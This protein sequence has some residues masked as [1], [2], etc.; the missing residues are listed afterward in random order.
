MADDKKISELPPRNNPALTDEIPSVAGGIN[1]RMPVSSIVDLSSIGNIGPAGPAGPE[2]PIGA[3]GATGP[4]GPQGV[5]GPVAMEL[6]GTVADVAALPPTGNEL[7]DAYIVQSFDP[8]HLFVWD[9]DSW[10]DMG[11]FQGP[12]GEIGPVGPAGPQGPQGLPGEGGGGSGSFIHEPGTTP[13]AYVRSA[14]DRHRD[15]IHLF[16]FIPPSQHNAMLNAQ[17]GYIPTY[18]AA[19]DLR[20][21][22]EQFD[23]NVLP[24]GT[25]LGGPMI[26]L[27][28][29]TVGIGSTISVEKPIYLKGQSAN[30]AGNFSDGTVLHFPVGVT[31]FVIQSIGSTGYPE[32]EGPAPKFTGGGSLFENFALHTQERHPYGI[33]SPNFNHGF[34]VH[35]GGTFRDMR[36]R[37]FGGD[38]YHF[39]GA[40]D[41]GHP[42]TRGNVN[43]FEISGGR[44]TNCR[45]GM[46]VDGADANAGVITR[47]DFSGNREW[48]VQDLSFLGNSYL[49]CHVASNG[50]CARRGNDQGKFTCIDPVRGR[51]EPPSL[52]N[53]EVW[54][55]GRAPGDS[56]GSDAA[57]FKWIP[58]DPHLTWGGG[59]LLDVGIIAHSYAEG[60]ECAYFGKGGVTWH[61]GFEPGDYAKMGTH[62]LTTAAAS[63]RQSYAKPD[64]QGLL[65]KGAVFG[66]D[67]T[68]DQGD[69]IWSLEHDSLGASPI[70][71]EIDLYNGGIRRRE[72]TDD[73]RF[74]LETTANTT[75][76][77]G[78]PEPVPY[79]TY[80]DRLFLGAPGIMR[81]PTGGKWAPGTVVALNAILENDVFKNYKCVTAG[82]TATGPVGTGTGTGWVDGKYLDGS[83]TWEYLANSNVVSPWETKA[84]YPV[85][86][87]RINGY[88][89]PTGT[90]DGQVDGNVV[91]DHLGVTSATN[92]AIRPW[93]PNE[94]AR[95]GQLRTNKGQTYKCISVSGNAKTSGTAYIVVGGK[96]APATGGWAGPTGT[97]TSIVDGTVIWKNVPTPSAWTSTTDTLPYTLRSNVGNYYICVPG[98]SAAS[99]GPTGTANSIPGIH[100]GTVNWGF[101]VSNHSDSAEDPILRYDPWETGRL[102]ELTQKVTNGGNTYVCMRSGLSTVAPTGTGGGDIVDG[103]PG[104]LN[105]VLVWQYVPPQ[106]AWQPNTVYGV[107]DRV[108]NGGN[109]YSCYRGRTAG[110]PYLSGPVIG[111]QIQDGT[112]TWAYFGNNPAGIPNWALNTAYNVGD[113]VAVNATGTFPEVFNC[114]VA[115]TSAGGPTGGATGGPAGDGKQIKDNNVAWEYIPPWTPETVFRTGYA[116]TNDSGKVYVAIAG[117]TAAGPEG[118][119]DIVDGTAVWQHEVAGGGTIA[120]TP[121]TTYSDGVLR[122]NGGNT[123]RCLKDGT[124]A[125]S[126][127]PT[128]FGYIQDGTVEWKFEPR[129]DTGRQVTSRTAQ[130]AD[131]NWAVGDFVINSAPT[132]IGAPLGWRCIKAGEPALP[133]G[134][135]GVPAAVPAVPAQWQILQDS[136]S[137]QTIT[138][139]ASFTLT[140]AT[141]PHHTLVTATLTLTRTC[142]LSTVGDSAGLTYRITRTGGGPGLLTINFPTALTSLSQNEWCVVVSDGTNWYLESRGRLQP[143]QRQE[144]IATNAAFTITPFST[145]QRVLHT[146]VLTADRAVTL[147]TVNAFNGLTYRITRSGGGAFNLNVGTGPLKA[148]AT[149]TWAEFTFDGA[150]YYLAAYGAL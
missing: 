56:P 89:G 3:T 12:Q 9:G 98:I 69:Q 23:V 21:A 2:G 60:G 102:Y 112:V 31:G 27:P 37:N 62:S 88:T 61:S 50:I 18:D 105:S 74:R 94:V 41:T 111:Q 13:P 43:R 55:P 20:N 48:G 129:V 40:G 54:W 26:L 144:T 138:A 81:Q 38:G 51:T 57:Y 126:G 101:I 8:D 86:T 136:T 139:D 78:R 95:V 116:C 6:Q 125:A 143:D 121:L 120:W 5:P 142:T 127:G 25:F 77:F 58:D 130:P 30:S 11:P 44:V 97:G 19:Q 135:G 42:S 71:E 122:T 29:G 150:A 64:S 134:P 32:V 45:N 113:K 1:Y 145:A 137:Q 17:I 33:T 66:V 103:D 82:T 73:T 141:S 53:P 16:D 83:V 14:Q 100:D 80:I 131:H 65:Y 39:W 99:G 22:I 46:W 79:A 110:A 84:V 124:S 85:D 106:P 34:V 114:V 67:N 117:R 109:I 7:S 15:T 10:E 75:T 123:Y 93:Q 35:G 118:R 140:A 87:V 147:S 68:R 28:R 146:G 91:W 92:V 128:G 104:S 119:S 76:R 72:G 149:N 90:A 52:D 70:A 47:G 148:L 133:A 4:T 108:L 24:T 36:I 63:N 115:G 96:T 49:S 132:V 59:M 107:G